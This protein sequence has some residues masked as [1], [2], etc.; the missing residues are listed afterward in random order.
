M[1]PLCPVC[2]QTR[3]GG[4]QTC[5]VCE[6]SNDPAQRRDHDLKDMDNKMSVNEAREAY[7]KGLPIE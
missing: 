5:E 4:F 3:L 2:G 7:R 1:K 6:W